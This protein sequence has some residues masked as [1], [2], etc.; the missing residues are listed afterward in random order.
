MD[1]RSDLL[2]KNRAW[3]WLRLVDRDNSFSLI[4][5][6]Y[7]ILSYQEGRLWGHQVGTTH[8]GAPGEGGAPWWVVPNQGPLSGG[9]WL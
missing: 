6:K 9:S 5:W 8:L 2:R 7:V 1:S 4:F 3:R